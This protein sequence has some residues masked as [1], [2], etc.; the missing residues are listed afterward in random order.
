MRPCRLRIGFESARH[1][2]PLRLPLLLL[3]LAPFGAPRRVCA[4]VAPAAVV[5]YEPFERPVRPSLPPTRQGD[6]VRTAVDAFILARLEDAGL[7]PAP[8][9][10][11]ITLLRRV[12]FDLIGLPPTAEEVDAFLRDQQ[13]DAYEN[14]VERLL[15][16]PQYGERWAQH[17]LDVVRYADSNGFEYDDPRPNAWRF[18][19]WVIRSLNE[20]RPYDEFVRLQVGGDELAPESAEA[21]IAT[22][23][24]RLGPLRLNAGNQDEEKNRQEIL[25]EMT[26]AI[27]S[28]FLGLTVGCARCH[29]HKFDPISQADYF[30]LQAFFA[31][32]EYKDHTL[33]SESERASHDRDMKSWRGEVRALKKR[34]KRLERTCRARI[35]ETKTARLPEQVRTALAIAEKK[36]SDQQKA[37]VSEVAES[38]E[39][40]AEEIE[41]GYSERERTDRASLQARIAKMGQSK[42]DPLPA[43]FA[44]MDR[45]SEA[46]ATHI[47]RRGQPGQHLDEVQPRFMEAVS[48]E[49]APSIPDPK[50]TGIKGVD[51]QATTG[52]RAA[53]ARWLASKKNPLTA[54]VMVNRIWQHHFGRG[55]VATPNDFG[56]M[57]EYP[58]HPQLLD[59]LATEFVAQGWSI[60]SLH[61]LIVNSATY[62]QSSRPHPDG[63]AADPDNELFWR[64]PRRR[65]DAET[66]RDSILAIS[67]RLNRTAHGPGV[68]APLSKEVAAL[69]YKG[70]WEPTPDS[71]EHDRRTIYLFVK[72]NLRVPF[73][74]TFDAPS[75]LI[76][77]ASRPVSTHAGQALALLNGP[78]LTEQSE[79]LARRLLRTSTSAPGDSTSADDA[80]DFDPM[81][82]R[83][84]SLAL[85]RLPRDE[86]FR[87]AKRFLTEQVAALRHQAESGERVEAP[88]GF[89]DGVDPHLAT[90]LTDFSLVVLNLDELLFVD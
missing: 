72:R 81:I 79:A 54:R 46:P 37:L 89:P 5:E 27:G 52:R 83:A 71:A 6:W 47:L 11:R 43:A 28:T 16:N 4:E 44:V 42:P 53:L 35:V 78:F 2:V 76:S 51:G 88:T 87:A 22:G 69:L 31:A 59:W 17:W 77:C 85:S 19:D 50:S 29:D 48:W 40:S 36:R 15:A 84:Y 63:V 68:R 24:N 49:S 80:I 20:D 64:M 74:E 56:L 62:R 55:L 10:D 32:T 86:E 13:P 66:F 1:G 45:G 67:G 75:T 73:L 70:K 14:V 25:V 12:T 18:R 82:K 33:V 61:R 38:L 26:D 23:F 39:V 8:H 21:L 7:K 60:K 90:A 41:M 58:S 65:L 34:L 57:G 3:I 9:A 30:H